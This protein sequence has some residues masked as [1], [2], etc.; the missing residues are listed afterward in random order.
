MVSPGNPLKPRA[1]MAPLAQRLRSAR[2][3]ADPPRV[4]ATDIEATLGR[5]FT[6]DTVRD[7]RRRFPHV[8]FV[9]LMGADVWAELPRWRQWR[10]FTATIP[11]AVHARPG[12]RFAPLTAVAGHRLRHH[13]LPAG[14]THRLAGG[15]A[16]G[17]VFLALP[18]ID[19]SATALRK[20]GLGLQTATIPPAPP[21]DRSRS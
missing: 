9:W 2:G 18:P 7:L 10:R 5:H 12:A 1:G 13:R 3:I 14:A 19:I 8:R 11:M 20:A 16:P 21:P 17:W 15:A 4:V 6:V